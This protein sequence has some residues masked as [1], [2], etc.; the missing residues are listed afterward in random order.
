MKKINIVRKSTDFTR[1][2]HKKHS[3]SNNL[4]I[5]NIENNTDNIPKFGIAVPKK[6][7]KAVTRNKIKRQ[8]KNIIDNNKFIYEK[9]INYIII[10]R[11]GIES[12]NYLEKEKSL[13]Q[14]MNK[15]K[16][17]L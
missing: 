11:Q 10:V 6:I 2:I 3:K 13:I 4:Y 15:I 9:N 7:G 14:L 1:I 17:N 12:V 8:I 16:E 5:I